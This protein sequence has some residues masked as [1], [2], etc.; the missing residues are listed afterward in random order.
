[1]CLAVYTVDEESFTTEYE[2]NDDGLWTS[3]T[4]TYNNAVYPHWAS[5]MRQT[6]QFDPVVKDLVV[7]SMEYSL[8]NDEW[9]LLDEGRTWKRTVS[10][11]DKGNVTGVSVATYYLENF[12]TT[13]KTTVTYNQDAVADTWKY[14]EL[15]SDQDGGL[16]MEEF[17]TLHDM[18]WQS[19][20]GQIVAED[21]TALF[22]GNNRLKSAIVSEGSEDVGSLSATYEENGNY[23]YTSNYFGDIL[24][25]EVATITYPDSY[26]SVTEEYVYYAD[27]NGDGVVTEDER[28]ESYKS[29][30]SCDEHGETV[31]EETFIDDEFDSGI[32]YDVEYGEYSYPET[33]TVS[34]Y[35]YDTDSYVPFIKI[36]RSNFVDVSDASVED[37]MAAPGQGVTEVY[38][39][40]GLKLGGR[41]DNL[42]AGLYI[43]RTDGKVSK[44]LKR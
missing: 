3:M 12:E 25:Y 40:Q 24:E 29:V 30:V 34:E 17:F 14:E 28:L 26:G 42:P 7:E 33:M 13:R 27:V 19:T 20:D 36:V 41:I 22:A 10:R 1:M 2:Y 11:D 6:R 23:S 31:S 4:E 32:K 39:L 37:V 38:S 15:S 9:A 18:E 16:Y 21:I 8:K 35:D 43:V 5:S 44:L